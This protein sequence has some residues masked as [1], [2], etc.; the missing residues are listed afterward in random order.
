MN[1]LTERIRRFDHNRVGSAMRKWVAAMHDGRLESMAAAIMTANTWMGIRLLAK[2]STTAVVRQ[3]R[4]LFLNWRDETVKSRVLARVCSRIVA[5][6]VHAA[7]RKWVDMTK[8]LRTRQAERV[9]DL[10]WG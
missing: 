6:R 7:M 4:S 10:S 5:S 3:Q 9:R 1:L 8:F 2:C